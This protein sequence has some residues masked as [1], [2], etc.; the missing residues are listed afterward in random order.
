MSNTEK[1][2][3]DPERARSRRRQVL[4]AAAAC[5]SRSGFHG[6]SMAEISK[7]AGMSAGH[8]YNYFDGKD[9][10]IAA[11]VEENVERVTALLQDLEARGDVLQA[12]LDDVPK[13]VLDH[14]NRE[15]WKL[16]LEI[17][18]EASRNPTIAAVVHDADRRTRAQFRAIFKAGRAQHGLSVDDAVLEGRMDAIITIFQGLS[19]RAQHNPDIDSAALTASVEVAMKALLFT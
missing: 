18:A 2:H 7:A 17:T 11:F 14:L 12:L 9:A 3:H 5:F 10:I 1:R 13:S 16:P 4:E 6:A 15:T 19:A 8:I